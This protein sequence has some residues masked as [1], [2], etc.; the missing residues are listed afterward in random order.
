MTSICSII[1]RLAVLILVLLLAPVKG[2]TDMA[3]YPD[4]DIDVSFD[5]AE[6]KIE[7]IS[8]ISL[9]A[10]KEV[11][12][13][14]GPLKILYIKIN[15]LETEFD[16]R[17]EVFEFIPDQDGTI[18]IGYEGIFEDSP[19]EYRSDGIASNVIDDRGIS[20]TGMWY[21]AIEGLCNYNLKATLPRGYKAVSEADEIFQTATETGV[22]FN[23][24]F[25][26]P[27][28]GINLI[29]T[30]RYR[31]IEDN[32][33]G[34]HLAAY[35]FKEDLG[36][37]RAYLEY[38]KQYIE[39]YEKLVG[40]YPY[41]RFSIVENFLPTGYSMP[42]YTL[43]GS[44]VVRL[45]FIIETSL[46]HEIL[47][48]WF[49]NHVYIDH[50]RGN[51][52][53]GLTA[54]LS[55]HL[56]K[57]RKGEGWIYRKQIMI[58]YASFVGPD[59]D[60]PVRKFT[61]RYDRGS[62][63]IGYG[64]VAMMFH[65]L[66][67]DF[68]DEKFFL[69]LKDFINDN[70]YSKASWQELRSAFQKYFDGNLH[71]F[72]TEWLDRT[73]LPDLNFEDVEITQ[74]GIKYELTFKVSQKGEV[75]A[76]DI[77]LSIYIDG[78]VIKKA[79]RIESEN[80]SFKFI[81]PDMPDKVVF[82]EDYDVGRKVTYKEFPPVVGRLLGEKKLL[83]VKPDHETEIY[84]AVTDKFSG[85]D[86]IIKSPEE[87]KNSDIKASSVVIL[88]QD[89][90][91]IKRIYG[92]FTPVEAGFHITVRKNP[93]NPEKVVAIINGK[94][95][96]ETDRA[97]RKIGH[98]GKYSTLLFDEGKNIN[99]EI[100]ESD[101]GIVYDLYSEP[102][103]LDLSAITRLGNVIEGVSDK[104]IIYVGEMHD[105]FAHHSVQLNIISG[106]YKRNRKIAIGMEMFQR[107]YQ[108]KL[109]AYIAGEM[110]EKEFLKIAEYF[111]Q[112]GFD[113][114]LYKPILDFAREENVPVIALNT[115]REIVKKVSA[116]GLDSLTD[117]ERKDIPDRMD[118]SDEEYR[119]RLK[120]IFEMHKNNKEKAFD[121]FYESQVLWDETM[122]MS[123]SEYL[124]KEPDRQVIV[125]VGR[126]HLSY[127]SGIPNRTFA[128]TG[129]SYSIVLI[130]SEV[131]EGIAD[132]I[133]FSS[134][135]KG[136]IAPRMMV[137]VEMEEMGFKITG[138]SAHSISEK[139]GVKTGDILLS[140]DDVEIKSIADLKV[141]LHYKDKGDM[142]KLKVF[143]PIEEE[144][145]EEDKD[146]DKD[147]EEDKEVEGE[148]ILID[149]KL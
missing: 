63:S 78:D 27:V 60:F 82:D 46:G 1:N 58:D 77:P 52:A 12:F 68:G 45:P 71:G 105:E 133:V 73:G 121:F 107:P 140:V 28:D 90:P 91:V 87:V 131:E 146:I 32:L 80:K 145:E 148:E 70:R 81:L 144:A 41:K 39:L 122:S 130:D 83:I 18:E 15:D 124:E 136:A 54:Y 79:I 115:S 13:R 43:L 16:Q 112:W 119:T 123:I 66:R 47:H 143:R 142:I 65:M 34:I 31:V 98:Y 106:I 21:P 2:Y 56:Y 50:E 113:Y 35:F 33:D 118:F 138:F 89:N 51:W 40:E 49:G 61:G 96:E 76:L 14:K 110:E 10:G 36:L 17:Q 75:F 24:I 95:A 114:N 7:G 117:E 116:T 125:I 53:E 97:F 128:R 111:K 126:G 38:S 132:Y 25:P 4:C 92:K 23:F 6:S 74:R 29:A 8:R 147:K 9:S 100:E 134:A 93:W 88:G 139:A 19:S 94:S 72:F 3:N 26:Y 120:E 102:Q 108:E 5:I 99:K 57:E 67:R 149:L 141:Y 135:V 86:V 20:L 30:D 85:D 109:D 11:F 44:S 127:G 103:A 48:Q 69:A 84:K 129:K 62:Q 55:D 101:R 22:E 59:N 64:K 42:T 37:A 104:K 137:Y